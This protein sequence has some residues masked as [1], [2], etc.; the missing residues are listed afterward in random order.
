MSNNYCWGCG[1]SNVPQVMRYHVWILQRGRVVPS[2]AYC[3]DDTC[4]HQAK[5]RES[6]YFAAVG[7]YESIPLHNS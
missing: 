2:N 3:C 4:H 6:S 1:L 5:T 7:V